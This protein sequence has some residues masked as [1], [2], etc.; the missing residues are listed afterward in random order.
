MGTILD[1]IHNP[2][3]LKKLKISDLEHLAGEIRELMI[4]VISKRGGH[5]ASS[6]GVV[7]L[8]LAL[9]FV[10]NAP[11]DRI[12][13]D[14][15]HQCYAHKI[16]TGRREL[17]DKIRCHK[18]ISG[19]PKRSESVYD[20]F[21]VGHS[22]TS[23]SAALGIALARDLRREKFSVINIIGD[24]AL[25]G[26]MALEALNFAGEIK[27]DLIVILNDNEMSIDYNVGGLNS[28][29]AKLRTGSQILPF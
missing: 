6:L 12:I 23:L 11:D 24:G 3:D 1:L 2:A 26:G 16:L 25:T 13:W 4:N 20:A 8:T 5:L 10:F 17:F 9:H 15:G 27:T 7:E 21:S 22:S 29:L 28:Y 19:F 14:V 18:G